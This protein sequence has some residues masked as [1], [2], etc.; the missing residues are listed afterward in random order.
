MCLL[1]LCGSKTIK[2]IKMKN[3]NNSPLGN[4]MYAIGLVATLICA[5]IFWGINLSGKEEHLFSGFMIIHIITLLYW[6]P[7]F[8]TIIFYRKDYN[9]ASS[10][11]ALIIS[12]ISCF[13][14][15]ANVKIFEQS[16]L[17]YGISIVVVSIAYILIPMYNEMPKKLQIISA[18]ILGVAIILLLY[19]SI[20]LAPLYVFGVVGFLVL[21]L[22]SLSLVPLVMLITLVTWGV[23]NKLFKKLS[24]GISFALLIIVAFTA[25]WNSEVNKINKSVSLISYKERTFPHWI[26]VAQR[27]PQGYF[28]DKIL[29]VDL[30]YSTLDWSDNW[31]MFNVPTR[32]YSE[33][34]VH[35]PL[36]VIAVL[37]GNKIRLTEN[38]RIDVLK[39]TR[40]SRH[41]A[42]EH[43]WSGDG[44]KTTDIETE[45]Q[46]WPQ[47][48]I[49]YTEQVIKLRNDR[50]RWARGEAIYTFHLPEGSV[51]SSLSLWID[52]EER[53][54]ILTTKEK[55]D[56]AYNTIVGVE[57]RDPSLV[58]WQEGSTVTVRLFPVFSEEE[59][60]FKIGV[61]TPLGTYKDKIKYE[62]VYFEGTDFSEAKEHLNISFMQETQDI[63]Y[64]QFLKK[65]KTGN[66]QYRGSYKS[67]W[68]IVMKEVPVSRDG[69]YFDGKKY[70]VSKM[71]HYSH[72]VYIKNVYLDIN[73]SWTKDD[74]DDVWKLL[75]GKQVWVNI[76]SDMVLL[77]D[78]NRKNMF[79]ELQSF[80]FSI[81]PIHK[82]EN[83]RESMIVSKSTMY[84]PNIRDLED[85]F[86]LNELKE[87]IK[88]YNKILFYDLGN[89]LSPYLQTMLEYRILEYQQGDIKKLQEILQANKFP[90]SMP[91][92]EHSI[93]IY[94]AGINI[95]QEIGASFE[96]AGN[97]PDHLM[98]LF[99]YNHILQQYTQS[100]QGDSLITEQLIMEATEANIVSPVSSLVV[101]ET[102][103]DYDRFDIKAA[104]KSIGNAST[105][106]NTPVGDFDGW[107]L[108][109]M[110]IIALVYV[111]F[112][113]SQAH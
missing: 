95:N 28:I 30:V 76:H 43:L 44:I 35:D 48:R 69:F 40:N 62:P 15:N 46:I 107:V 47:Y 53:K 90:I 93:S 7:I 91:E 25:I 58:H 88:P 14:L 75:K 39:S 8:C 18:F 97:A 26:N 11:P 105:S 81:F 63:D 108:L 23:K 66:Y 112:V 57:A 79:K 41:H 32:S 37:T 109:V 54:G 67:D 61:T 113:R 9:S 33:D 19:L 104:E 5:L 87:T 71:E 1:C 80:Q 52:E 45:V 89:N 20:C 94:Q 34:K 38:E 13:A 101:L 17:W 111:M 86:F 106:K 92:T 3:G 59:R 77:T 24:V 96:K 50:D 6:I 65:G 31:N 82:V 84:S 74:F 100:W 12:F 64:P 49:A 70:F 22:P 72:P 16:P 55:A 10:Y 78:K 102:Q 99:A 56:K 4:T 2:T 21:G 68:Q 27:I 29:K 83:L 60:Q 73:K 103:A 51:V 110:G 98:R 42:E 36:V 85:T